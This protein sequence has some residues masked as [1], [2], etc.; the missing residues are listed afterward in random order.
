MQAIKAVQGGQSAT[1]VAKADGV[2]RQTI[3]PLKI[4]GALIK[5]QFDIKL[6]INTLSRVMK[7]L[8]FT[9]QK[10][11]Y[12]AW[13]QDEKLVPQWEEDIYPEIKREAKKAGATI[14]FAD[15]SGIRSG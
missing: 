4:I 15:E 2:N 14:Y 10:P 7:F 1:E 8:G 3:Y 11:L 13:Q 12:Q 6:S 5:K 9:A